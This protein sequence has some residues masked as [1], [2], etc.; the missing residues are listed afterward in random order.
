MC[1]LWELEQGSKIWIQMRGS[2]FNVLTGHLCEF[3]KAKTV[4]LCARIQ[5]FQI[6][7]T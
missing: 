4:S 1:L 2:S 7:K 3:G 5:L 6:R